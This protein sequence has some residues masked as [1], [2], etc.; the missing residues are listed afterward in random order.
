MLLRILI[1]LAVIAS[2]ASGYLQ[3]ALHIGQTPAEF[4]ADSDDTLRV[5]TWAFSIWGLIYAWLAVYAVWQALPSTPQTP[6]LRR[7]GWP[8]LLAFIG[9]GAWI[10]VAAFDLETLSIAVIVASGAVL[11]VP[12]VRAGPNQDGATGG[13]RVLAAFPLALLAGWLTFASAGNI[14][15]VLTGNGD[16]PAFLPPLGW[17]ATAIALVLLIG[18]WV[19]LRTRLWI[20]LLPIA[21]GLAGVWRAGGE[22]GNTELSMIAAGAAVLAVL[23][24]LFIAMRRR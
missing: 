3:V 23:L 2:I 12:L 18:S 22:D 11:I 7:M 4:A 6:F 10:F 24:A 9:I 17:A 19:A 5:A 13:E 15:T 8:A 14:L 16:L 21:W 20:Y 1:L